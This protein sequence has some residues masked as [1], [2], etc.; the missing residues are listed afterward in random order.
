MVERESWAPLTSI[1]CWIR[2]LCV[3][4]MSRGGVA[5]VRSARYEVMSQLS[6]GTVWEGR[7]AFWLRWG[8][9]ALRWDTFEAVWWVSLFVVMGVFARWWRL[10]W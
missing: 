1:S 2:V 10:F 4:G 8:F 3:G 6:N 7:W 5:L 9:F